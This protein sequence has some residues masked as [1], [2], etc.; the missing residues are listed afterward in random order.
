[1][2]DNAEWEAAKRRAATEKLNAL[3]TAVA[4]IAALADGQADGSADESA[5]GPVDGPADG[6]AYGPTD[7][8]AKELAAGPAKGPA[9]ETAAGAVFAWRDDGPPGMASDRRIEDKIEKLMARERREE[10]A[11]IDQK[12]GGWDFWQV[13]G[14]ILALF[15]VGIGAGLGYL[16]RTLTEYEESM[17]EYVLSQYLPPVIQGGLPRLFAHEA[18]LPTAYENAQ[19]KDRFIRELLQEGEL[20]YY[21]SPA[22]SGDG[23]EVYIFRAGRQ[24]MAAVRLRKIPQGR[25]GRWEAE[26]VELR[27]PIYGELRLLAPDDAEITVNG[28]PLPADTEVAAGLPYPELE[29]LPLGIVEL[30]TQKE[31]LLTGLYYRPEIAAEGFAGNSLTVAW[32]GEDEHKAAILPAASEDEWP[33]WQEMVL[34]DAR[35]YS[36]YLS[37]DAQFS[38]LA[39]R[40]IRE[41][42]IYDEIR[43]METIFYTDHTEVKFTDG[44]A[45]NFRLYGPDCLAA[46][47]EYRYLVYRGSQREYEFDTK[48]T[49]FYL[50]IGDVWRIGSIILR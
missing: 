18:S 7:G 34:E 11:L 2:M 23:R 27:L 28:Y 14:L 4:D 38:Q 49:F 45:G 30:P 47:V 20:A 32:D 16:W 5:S 3:K 43:T 17:P 42:K 40:L 44:T 41:A 37:R 35:I 19:A 24:V 33:A 9:V 39:A 50:K 36:F 10:R 15:L 25:F 26:A 1:M 13:Y 12:R 22:E 46:D 31:Y 48:A 8:P 6:L 21:R 29:N